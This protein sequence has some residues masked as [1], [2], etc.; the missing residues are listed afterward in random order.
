MGG[1]GNIISPPSICSLKCSPNSDCYNA[2]KTRS[3]TDKGPKP[4]CMIP[5][6]QFYTLTEPYRFKSKG[7]QIFC[8]NM[9]HKSM[10]TWSLRNAVFCNWCHHQSEVVNIKENL[11]SPS[12]FTIKDFIVV[13]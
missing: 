3:T 9:P 13:D 5:H 10:F 12:S 1:K 4:E 7:C 2:T 6:L 8:P 11:Y